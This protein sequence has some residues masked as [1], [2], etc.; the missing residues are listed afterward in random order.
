MVASRMFVCL[1]S[2][3][4]VSPSLSVYLSLSLS[5]SVITESHA[6]DN[7]SAITLATSRQMCCGE[8]G[9]Q[10]FLSCRMSYK[11]YMHMKVLPPLSASLGAMSEVV[12][13][14]PPQSF[15]T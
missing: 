1:Y 12:S 3:L 10:T 15:S 9:R 8:V 5:C 4:P 7:H 6:E 13:A 14:R 2:T 11:I